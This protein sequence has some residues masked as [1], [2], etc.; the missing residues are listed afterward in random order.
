MKNKIIEVASQLM[1][2]QGYTN[3]GLKE[4]LSKAGVPKGSFYHYFESKE[5]LALNILDY[6]STFITQIFENSITEHDENPIEGLKSFFETIH[7]NFEITQF[8]GG[9]PIGNFGQELSDIEENI[10]VKTDKIFDSLVDQ[11][12]QQLSRAHAMGLVNQESV[13]KDY[14]EFLFNCW[15]GAMLRAKIKK[16]KRPLDLFVEMMFQ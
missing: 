13:T 12:H 16:T 9:C 7:K 3:T 10:R 6:Y 15:E 2:F 8:T 5:D 1:H 11:V 4:I 14:A